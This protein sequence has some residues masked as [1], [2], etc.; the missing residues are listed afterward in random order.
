MR[1]KV[2]ADS[3]EDENENSEKKY[4]RWNESMNFESHL[5][6]GNMN[7]FFHPEKQ[8]RDH[9]WIDKLVN[10]HKDHTLEHQQSQKLA[11]LSFFLE[12]H[13]DCTKMKASDFYE[14]K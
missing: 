5:H 1:E 9:E 10:H 6:L 2:I 4:C 7:Y 8:A 3:S 12:T 11:S 13:S 14:T